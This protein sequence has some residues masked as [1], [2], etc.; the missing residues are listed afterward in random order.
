MKPRP[1][2]AQWLGLAFGAALLAAVLAVRQRGDLLRFAEDAELVRLR[3]ERQRLSA[4]EPVAMH[5]LQA[6][7]D[8]LNGRRATKQR[9]PEGWSARAMPAPNGSDEVS[10]KFTPTGIPTWAGLLNAVA[11]LVSVPGNRIVSVEIRS[12]GTLAEREIAS[13]EIVLVQ[14][15][16]TPSRR[17]PSGGTGLPGTEVPATP[18]AV[19]AGPSLRRPAA[20]A[21]PPAAGQA[22][23]PVRPDPRGPRAGPPFTQKPQPKLP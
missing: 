10:W 6:A 20:F 2:T 8:A 4:Y 13:V 11:A 7:A 9:W 1:T 16:A 15:T 18:P 22:S 14:P 17:N 23:A 12:R 19:G 5:A 3:T 21:E